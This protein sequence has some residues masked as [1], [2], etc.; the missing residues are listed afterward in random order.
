MEGVFG[1]NL[2]AGRDVA[3]GAAA[4]E[5]RQAGWGPKSNCLSAAFQPSA[6]QVW[7]LLAFF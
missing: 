5:G 4:G 3:A 2:R 1:A 6:S 7:P